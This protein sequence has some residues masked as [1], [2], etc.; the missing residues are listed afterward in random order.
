M[1]TIKNAV[2]KFFF[3]HLP[4]HKIYKNFSSYVSSHDRALLPITPASQQTMADTPNNTPLKLHQFQITILLSW[5]AKEMP[6]PEGDPRQEVTIA[7]CNLCDCPSAGPGNVAEAELSRVGSAAPQSHQL[8]CSLLWT[9]VS[10]WSPAG[11]AQQLFLQSGKW[12]WIHFPEVDLLMALELEV[13]YL[14][15]SPQT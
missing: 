4:G 8:S 15:C 5:K 12:H 13:P 10:A 6:N 1:P 7:F 11:H 9:L 2:K 14:P 3:C